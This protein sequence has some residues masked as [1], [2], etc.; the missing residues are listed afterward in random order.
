METLLA[1]YIQPVS[2]TEGQLKT[3]SDRYQGRGQEQIASLSQ[4]TFNIDKMWPIEDEGCLTTDA[5][6]YVDNYLQSIKSEMEFDA[7]E[8]TLLCP[9][10]PYPDFYGATV[11]WDQMLQA[12]YISIASKENNSSF[13]SHI[14]PSTAGVFLSLSAHHCYMLSQSSL[15]TMFLSS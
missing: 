6:S 7:Y 15:R 12:G 5:M 9:D 3:Q 13:A 11:D 1:K 14:T 10:A 2:C 4:G 8:A